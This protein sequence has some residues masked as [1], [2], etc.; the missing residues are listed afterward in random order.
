MTATT[1]P[2]PQQAR[3]MRDGDYF[4]CPDCNCEITLRHQGD[5]DKMQHMEMFTCCC[6]TKM[7]FEKRPTGV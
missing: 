1:M 3:Q 4:V 6:G 5:P 7:Q 2:T